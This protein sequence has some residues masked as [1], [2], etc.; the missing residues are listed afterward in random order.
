[1]ILIN[2]NINFFFTNRSISVNSLT[3][4]QLK[5]LLE[6]ESLESL[7]IYDLSSS[8]MSIF[9]EIENFKNLKKLYVKENIY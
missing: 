9:D 2:K 6:I 5:N 7:T 8:S 3:N 4:E 1:L